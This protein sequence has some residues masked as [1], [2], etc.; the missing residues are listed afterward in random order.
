MLQF[1]GATGQ[2]GEFNLPLQIATAPDGTIYVVDGGNFRVQAFTPEGQF[3][4]KVG[5]VGIKTGQFSRPKG[6]AVDSDGNFYVIDTGFGNFQVFSKDGQ[7]LLFV[8]ARGSNGGP[9]EYMLPAGIA[10]DEDGRVYM[11]DQYFK[12]V[13]V[14]RPARLQANEGWLSTKNK[15]GKKK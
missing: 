10:V 15:P 4:R 9:G 12:K 5:A 7:L 11:V 3:I 6:I 13:D 1:S 8:G 14:F 2:P